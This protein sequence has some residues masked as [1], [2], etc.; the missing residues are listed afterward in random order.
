[1]S[2]CT[3]VGFGK[4]F[5]VVVTEYGYLRSYYRSRVEIL[6]IWIH[7]GRVVTV[8]TKWVETSVFHTPSRIYLKHII[9][10]RY[11]K[12]YII[13]TNMVGVTLEIKITVYLYDV[14]P[15]GRRDT[16]A[17]ELSRVIKV[18][19]ENYANQRIG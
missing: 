13:V 11:D 16:I 18:D 14:F 1:M 2:N 19:A 5:R 10:A 3:R 6:I 8:R 15:A 7:A 9:S 17:S 12:R 4:I